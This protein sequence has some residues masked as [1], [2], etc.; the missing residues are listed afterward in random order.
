MQSPGR[1]LRKNERDVIAAML[2]GKPS[3][4]ELNS[5][6]DAYLVKDLQDGGMGSIRVFS[7]ENGRRFGA[8]VAEA[9]YTGD[10]GVLVSIVLNTDCSGRLFE[11]DFWKVDFSPMRRYPSPPDLRLK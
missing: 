5:D 8:A 9:E 2:R 11:V 3:H 6:F 1:P 10:D 7:G 4:A